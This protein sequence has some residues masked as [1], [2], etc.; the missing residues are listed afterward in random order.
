M[1]RV[2]TVFCLVILGLVGYDRFSLASALPVL[3]ADA[4]G[5]SADSRILTA[6]QYAATDT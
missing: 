5:D 2:E 4:T 6:I 3:K 1:R